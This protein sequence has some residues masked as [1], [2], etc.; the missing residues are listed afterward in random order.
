[1]K[2]CEDHIGRL[3][4]PMPRTHRNDARITL[5]NLSMGH[6]RAK[7][8]TIRLHHID[9]VSQVLRGYRVNIGAALRKLARGEPE[10]DERVVVALLRAQGQKESRVGRKLLEG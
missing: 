4:A 9:L 1:M 2:R 8:R 3:C 5:L 7:V 6:I 10:E